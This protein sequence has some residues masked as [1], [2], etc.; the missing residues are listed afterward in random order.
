MNCIER[1]LPGSGAIRL[2]EGL[3][4]RQALVH[5]VCECVQAFSF[6]LVP[7][8]CPLNVCIYS[9]WQDQVRALLHS[10]GPSRRRHLLQCLSHVCPRPVCPLTRTY[11]LCE[12]LAQ[13]TKGGLSVGERQIIVK[14]QEYVRANSFHKLLKHLKP[15]LGL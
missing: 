1:D 7:A 2:I 12:V 10:T 9:R 13:C 15:T 3:V 4:E 14:L 8:L 11:S 6:L 5:A